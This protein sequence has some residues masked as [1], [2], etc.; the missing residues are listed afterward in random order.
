MM[1]SSNQVMTAINMESVSALQRFH[2]T[3][4]SKLSDRNVMHLYEHRNKAFSVH[5]HDNINLALSIL[6]V[7]SHTP[8]ELPATDAHRALPTLILDAGSA[9]NVAASALYSQGYKSTV[10][11]VATDGRVNM[12]ME[13]T[14][15]CPG[16]LTEWLGERAD[17]GVV[18]AVRP[19]VRKDVPTLGLAC[20]DPTSVSLQLADVIDSNEFTA[21]ESV[22]VATNTREIVMPDDVA[23]FERTKIEDVAARCNVAVTVR[24]KKLFDAA[25]ILEIIARL[26]GSDLQH[27]A[28]V[29]GKY[30]GAAAAGVLEYCELQNDPAL[31]GRLRVCELS[32]VT[33]MQLDSCVMR[34]L[35]ILPYPGD[36]GKNASLF[37][38]LN[39][40]KSS[41]GGRLLRRWL[42]QPLQ[43]PEEI[44]QRLDIVEMFASA[45]DF[46]KEIRDDHLSKL[47]DLH[48]LCR[49]FTR[50]GGKRASMEDVVRL[51]QC[52]VRL[53][54][55][56]N[57]LSNVG[58]GDDVMNKK[59]SKPLA[60][61]CA[62]LENFEKLVETT[63]DL[64]KIANGEFVVAPSVDPQL[65]RLKEMQDKVLKAI[66]KE[67]E[68]VKYDL[69]DTVKLERKDNLGYFFRLTRKEERMI[70]GKNEFMVIETR[71]DG[72]RFQTMNLRRESRE[73][74]S[75]AE[76]YS[77]A[78]KDARETTLEVAGTYVEVFIDIAAL[79]A[80]LDVL[81]AFAVVSQESRA[82][83]VRPTLAEAGTGLVVIQGRHPIVEENLPDNVEY[84]A[85]DIDLRR[86][87]RKDNQNNQDRMTDEDVEGEGGSVILVTGPNMGGK[88][89]YIRS[90]GVLT[91]MAHIGMFVPAQEAN[92]PITDRIFARV[93]AA[94]NQHRAVSTFM[95]E[96]LETA[97]I[98]RSAT[99]RSLV[100]I[101]ELGRGT[102]TTDGFGLACA[103][104][105]HIAKSIRSACMFATHFY[106]LTTVADEEDMK[107][108]VYNRH[109]TAVTN[110]KS[111]GSGSGL[112]FLYEVRD[113][114]CDQSFGVH[115]AEMANF[116]EDV[117]EAARQKAREM[118]TDGNEHIH[119]QLGSVGA[120]DTER[121]EQM[122]Y[123]LERKINAFKK[124]RRTEA[125]LEESI[126]ELMRMHGELAQ[127][128]NGFVKILMG[129]A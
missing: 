103:I 41:M 79:V 21:L 10:W 85:N 17:D 107:G 13:G 117:L 42:S 86:G 51:Y 122:T 119:A 94:D 111:N 4:S 44:N 97:A 9:R 115:V 112:T 89:T 98:L 128:E 2:K 11:V 80:E 118:E 58:Q 66:C 28:L 123:E 54:I 126:D 46:R 102:G 27:N 84:I 78:E 71:K 68:N 47:P 121:G 24:K 129:S 104:S 60:Q 124:E 23:Q 100:I 76:E 110:D 106:E 16:S 69:S 67:Y 96:M 108:A 125:E 99:A 64:E 53:P 43:S 105:R 113:G 74:E 35:N 120:E 82:S 92:V 75:I 5:G 31:D 7:G 73:Y 77:K 83:Y 87:G 18:L 65:G 40:C 6:P 101:D 90:A 95:S 3:V 12:N 93:G 15:G 88:S 34:A 59:F 37:G 63:I 72:V 61:L 25:D 52:A 29:D 50:D 81:S 91:L 1:E 36:G 33:S 114:V 32:V 116:P 39:K 57:K 45:P 62:E 20:W 127:S 56:N 38:L 8:A 19:I 70:R 26:S 14:P 109:V 48:A 22:F 49:R 30:C 55:L